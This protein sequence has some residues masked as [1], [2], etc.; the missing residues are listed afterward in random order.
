M[1]AMEYRTVSTKLPADELTMF[2]VHCEKKGVTPANLIRDLILREM[3]VT[4]P[5]TVAGKNKIKF[6]KIAGTFTWSIE[7]DSGKKIEVLKN[8]SPAFIE[9]LASTMELS[10]EERATFIQKRNSKSI[11]I[12]SN[13]IGRVF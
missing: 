4:V 9:N 10:L 6:D 2:K 1:L 5:N 11:P 8:I 12:P 13:I 7:T 3:K